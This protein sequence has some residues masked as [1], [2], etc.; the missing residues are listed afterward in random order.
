[1]DYWTPHGT[2]EHAGLRFA[3][4]TQPDCGAAAP[5]IESD[6]H[7]AVS[8]RTKR[9]KRAGECLLLEDRWHSLFYDMAGA[10]R[11]A[12]AESWGVPEDVRAK[13]EQ[14]LGRV[15]TRGDVAAIAARMDFEYLRSWCRDEWRYVT[16]RVALLTTDGEEV[17]DDYVEYLGRV[18]DSDTDYLDE[19]GGELAAEIAA[20]VGGAAVVERTW[21]IRD[22][23]AA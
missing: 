3:V 23:V 2:I 22:A 9:D 20:S 8:E 21:R 18:E 14:R 5:W 16:V 4:S 1:M 7:G 11:R 6:G 10:V 12:R 19:C 13:H 15:L 17:G